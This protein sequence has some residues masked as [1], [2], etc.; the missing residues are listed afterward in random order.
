MGIST[1]NSDLYRNST[2]SAYP[3]LVG[4]LASL[5]GHNSPN[6]STYHYFFYNLQMM[7]NC[8]SEYADA[9]AVFLEPQFIID[10][11]SLINIFPNPVKS[12]CTITSP[13]KIKQIKIFDLSARICKLNYPN[14]KTSV[15]NLGNLSKGIYTIE[16][17]TQKESVKRQLIVQ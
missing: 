6:S 13:K 14:A 9:T 10:N 5:T 17:I 11:S 8:I 1:G 2:G 4:N 3:Y 16:I 7:E 12:S 15:L